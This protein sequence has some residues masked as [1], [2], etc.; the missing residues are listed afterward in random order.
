MSSSH[1]RPNILFVFSDQQRWDTLGCYGQPLEVTP[2]LDRMAAEGVRFANAFTCQPVCGPA[3][4][5][6]QTGKYA[7]E[8]GCF[9][10]AIALP[11]DE[12][13]IA[14]RLSQDGYEVG[15]IGKWHLASTNSK[16]G[17]PA[18]Y[19]TKPVPPE[20]RGG[21]KDY[22]LASDVLEFT[23]HGYDGYMFDA[24]MNR[25]DF[26]GYRV[27]CLTDFALDYLRTRDGKRPFF[28]FLSY[29]EPHHQN[30]HHCYEGPNGSK[31]R[32]KD[33]VVPGDL[34]DTE[35]DWRENY[36]D[37]L[38]C[39]ASLDHN[40]GRIRAELDRLGLA[41]NTLIVY[42]SD[43]GS[44]FCTR[45]SEYKRAC[46]DGCTH[47]PMVAYGPG[48]TGGEVVD[49][50]VSLIDVPPTILSA[51]GVEVP[52]TMQGRAVQPLVDGTAVDWPDNVF[53]QISESHV[54][55]AIR[56]K[57]WKY[58]VRAP[59]RSGSTDPDS[60]LYVEDY[61]YDLEAD[62]H[63][64]NNLVADPSLADVRAELADVL[65]RRM[66]QAGEKIPQIDPCPTSPD[67]PDH[68]FS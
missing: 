54:G 51:A 41:D 66:V 1:D 35:G 22:W 24:D 67:R 29:I 62:P 55:R 3:R 61:L 16:F 45:N 57:K 17:P 10:N 32:F 21:Y 20:R 64:R 49:E 12:T 56:T 26:K 31:Q 4:A 42:T 2:N 9:R 44:H 30:D 68:T 38:G 15:Y 39:C 13:T 52:A 40:L 37:Y 60:D 19:V 6:L 53:M 34:V 23:S 7:T 46:H 11:T 63:E 59:H 25:V 43:H 48:F 5:C 58:S 8:V 14:H 18:D 50:L 36:P 27:D 47:I 65:K 33:F 28:L